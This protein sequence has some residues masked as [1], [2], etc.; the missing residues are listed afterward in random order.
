[1]H[2]VFIDLYHRFPMYIYALVV[3]FQSP[4]FAFLCIHALVDLLSLYIITANS[5]NQSI[6]Y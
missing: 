6:I 1:M 5:S 4:C 3:N 2:I